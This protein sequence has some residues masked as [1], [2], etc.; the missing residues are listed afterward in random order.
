MDGLREYQHRRLEVA[1]TVR[2]ALYVARARGDT[3]AEQRAR[4]LLARLAEDR[5]RLA[6]VGRFSRGKST[7]MNAILGAPYLPT[8]TGPMTSVVT[9]VRYGSRPRAWY[10][11][12]GS[13]TPIEGPVSEMARFVARSSTERAELQTL[14][15]DVE[16]PAELL[17]LGIAFID[18]PGV[19]ADVRASTATTR[20]FLP[21]A[22]A[23]ICVTGF[24]DPLTDTESAFLTEAAQHVGKLFLVVNKRD[25]LTD[26]EAADALESLQ[27][28]LRNELRLGEPRLFALSALRAQEARANDDPGLMAD[29]GLP[30]FEEALVEF[31][32]REKSGL[33][34]RTMAERAARLVAEL[35][36]DLT[37]GRLDLDG[38][39]APGRVAEEFESRID[40]LL[41][42]Q[43]TL[44]QAI[45]D[46]I[47]TD[48]PGLL[49]ARAP[50]RRSDL[51]TAL[52][53]RVDEAIAGQRADTAERGYVRTAR[54]RVEETCKPI[55]DAWMSR[56]AAQTH[57]AIMDMVA[58]GISALTELAL[59][60]GAIGAALDGLALPDDRAAS[61]AWAP[62]DLP[63]L[64]VPH[65]S[66]S[67]PPRPTRWG[68]GSP[69]ARDDGE[70]R[71]LH[72]AVDEAVEATD[73]RAVQALGVMARSW[74]QRL[75]EQVEREIRESA[76]R[77]RRN[78]ATRPNEEDLSAL[79][80]LADRLHALLGDLDSGP[81]TT[82]SAR[83]GN[84]AGQATGMPARPCDICAQMETELFDRLR[85]A[86]LRLAT[87][88]SDQEGHARGGGFCPLHSW[89]YAAM[90]SPVGISAGYAKLAEAVAGAL[91]ADG[92]HAAP[93]GS[94]SDGTGPIGG[95]RGP[96]P[97]CTAITERESAAVAD[98]VAQASPDDAPALCLNHLGTVLTAGP[99]LE[100]ARV[101]RSALASSLRR[102]AEDMRSFALKREALRGDLVTSE[103]SHAYDR[104]LRL[105]SGYSALARPFPAPHTGQ[106]PS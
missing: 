94:P 99:A 68:H 70:R 80:T 42:Q 63:A 25:L 45:A 50:A 58:D 3:H 2:A 62:E 27:R 6:V 35:R 98:I 46:R 90:A 65:L 51:R 5:F 103:E 8:G 78:L 85:H 20:R 83:N 1:D 37:L 97:V 47:D 44:C 17:R 39:P 7:L 30:E 92:G 59:A 81:L 102:G 14:S 52:D 28:R 54:D 71:R 16:V 86:Q 82:A 34:L 21:E 40:D 88:E 64:A 73:A 29:S 53:L 84:T 4:G 89:Q 32:T 12:R 19:G 72:R 23:L 22:D 43:S 106:A 13:D 105:L 104:V 9:T 75:C 87:R 77:F 101:L 69:F 93:D 67:V 79:R 24:D 41:A 11:R 66:W 61:A 31:L 49:S 10:R 26:R 33:F 60:P 38:G 74:T 36:R 57:E 95:R 91:D 48:L 15:V 18:T 76:D 55:V 100:V 56:H 96:C